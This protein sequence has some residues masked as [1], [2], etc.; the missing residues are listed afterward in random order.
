MKRY[1]VLCVLVCG[2]ALRW[3]GIDW[4]L[5]QMFHPDET[6]MLYAVNDISWDN[7]NPKFFAYG[8][9]PIYLLKILHSSNEILAK[10]LNKAPVDFFL[11]GRAVSALF[12][13]LTLLIL[14][15][16]G[17][18]FFSERV[19]LL[20]T[21]F[22][23]FTVLHI[24]LS[25]FLTVD[26]MLTCFVVLAI[27]FM[28]AL[29]EG[30]H[31]TRYY[32]LS[33]V[34][35][36]L[37]MATKVSALPLYGVFLVAHLCVALNS[38]WA[39]SVNRRSTSAL[40][41]IFLLALLLSGVT[42]FICEPYALLDFKEFWRQVNEQSQMVRG[43]WRPPYV[44]QYEHTTPYWYQ[45]SQL[46]RYSMGVPLS[47]LTLFGTIATL[48]I[49]LKDL[50]TRTPHPAPRTPQRLLLIFC[51]VIPV[52]VIV[53]GFHV[54]FLRYM[55]PLIPFFC[56][57]GALF[58]DW[59]LERLSSWKSVVWAVVVVVI[60]YAAF[61]SVAFVS[62]YQQEDPRKAACRWIYENI[63][64]GSTVLTELWEFAPFVPVDNHHPAQYRTLT[65]DLYSEDTDE[66]IKTIA[67]QLSEAEA[68]L[69][70]TR[71]M[72]GSVVRTSGQFP[73]TANYYK[74]LFDGSLGFEAV[75]PFTLYPSLL[76]ITFND[77]FADESFSVYDHP[78]AIVFRKAKQM[79]ADDLL[80]RLLTVPKL[81][82]PD[83]LLKRLL[84]YPALEPENVSLAPAD[85][86]FSRFFAWWN[87]SQLRMILLWL[88]VVE[89]LTLIAFPLTSL[90]F[91]HLPD[92]GY[93]VAKV[94]GLL[95]PAYLV[96]L[97][98]SLGYMPYTQTTI[99]IVIGL[100]AV[101]TLGIGLKYRASL[102][103]TLRSTWRTFLMHEL[104]FLIAFEAFLLF[105]AYNPDIFWSESSMDF[106][107]L[108]VLNRS[109]ILPPPD[110][111][112]S[113]FPLNY[114]YFGH[115]LIATLTK[116]TGLAPK[117]TYNLAFALVPALVIVEVFSLLYNLTK[118]YLWGGV[119]VL[120]SCVIGN[121]DGFFLLIDRLRGKEAYYR[122]FR[123]AHEVIPF[124][125]HEF[126][127][128]TFIFVD[129]H[130]HL[131]NMPFLL[132]AFLIGLHWL[133]SGKGCHRESP[134]AGTFS[135]VLDMLLT[136][137][138][139][140]TLGVISS[141]DYPTA[142]IF[143]I[144][145]SLVNSYR[146]RV[147][148]GQRWRMALRPLGMLV[149]IIPG[150]FLAYS[151]FYATFSRSGMGLG[152]VGKSTTQLSDFLTIFGLSLFLVFSWLIVKARR[153]SLHT[154]THP[155]R[156]LLS[157]LAVACVVWLVV[158]FGF[159][160]NYATF[161]FLLLLAVFGTVIVFSNG[162]VS[163]SRLFVW[164][165][166]IYACMITVGCE[167]VFVRDF[168][169]GGEYKRMNTIFKFY[170]PAWFLFSV[171]ATYSLSRIFP[172]FSRE[173]HRLR[174][175]PSAFR[176]LPT[177][178]WF[179]VFGLLVLASAVF[180]VMST[181][182]RRH[183]QDVYGRNYVSPTLNG[184]A[185]LQETRSDDY[186]AIQWLNDNV[187]GTPVILEATGNDYL[188]DYARISANTG[189]PTVLGWQSHADQREHW[190]ATHQRRQDVTEIYTNPN[191]ERTLQLLRYYHVAYICIGHTERRDFTAEQLQKFQ[192]APDHFT[193]VFQS[194]D[195]TIYQF[196][197]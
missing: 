128:W 8:S 99:T 5:P 65:L 6:R 73:L 3:Y 16:F 147:Q 2:I 189:L 80:A 87:T 12:G 78:K 54:K 84:A 173:H 167:I 162:Q 55:L 70:A 169:Q 60:G 164:L 126:P 179:L 115:Y 131:L 83:T 96:W 176:F 22:L 172:R 148:F 103:E 185:Y 7:L 135:V 38:R 181:Y 51:W 151:P 61:Y 119:G 95:L 28:T 45:L 98:V 108:T 69:L 174:K 170:L 117:I 74:L 93:G 118:R 178:L 57:C 64:S 13:S 100:L 191:L 17:K 144:L 77:D 109:D 107:F 160:V 194:G 183:H 20:S 125:V 158:F 29:L 40:T 59:L 140:G 143:L 171:A 197:R 85:M 32:L 76:G 63:E 97:G 146:N 58:V 105:R 152:L 1:L 21:A 113:G 34:V 121:L 149:I 190:H 72:Y 156:L 184:L 43:F 15:R 192:D 106:S 48:I 124:T 166:L 68:I 163:D 91:R 71:R 123:P 11:L 175:S 161:L 52:F 154:D 66:K 46:L 150:S 133:F 92:K 44:L 27:Y 153:V 187:S 157:L 196:I 168:L 195:T 112:I 53:G 94:I 41:G 138:I 25:H 159:Q 67:E 31:S 142:V 102:A 139:I 18:R 141:W 75:E 186:E 56:L 122:F 19:A 137:L 104:V 30:T 26:V 82:N 182:A 62:I 89:L 9:F 101:V 37:A 36:G 10:W 145:I 110:P 165:C 111:W 129:L 23:A 39:T 120:F 35:I 86:P 193:P 134:T 49:T 188:Y 24:Q 50:I 136:T 81:T 14:Y 127:F 4:A 180:P 155:W 116:L 42:F 33:G 79:S 47:L 177:A 88:L 90:T 114:Y 132:A 130:A